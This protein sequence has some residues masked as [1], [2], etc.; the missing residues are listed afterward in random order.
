[1]PPGYLSPGDRN[2]MDELH[3]GNIMNYAGSSV[4][5]RMSPGEYQDAVDKSEWYDR[6]M[7][8]SDYDQHLEEIHT[9]RGGFPRGGGQYAGPNS[10]TMIRL[11]EERRKQ[12]KDELDKMFEERGGNADW[13]GG[14]SRYHLG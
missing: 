2:R 7:S 14:S 11:E 5:P 8:Q 13:L 4:I 3:G 6:N 1:M 10:P 9:A 12:K